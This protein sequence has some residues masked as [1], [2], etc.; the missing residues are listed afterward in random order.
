MILKITMP[1]NMTSP[2]Q[3]HSFKMKPWMKKK[4]EWWSYYC[5]GPH[6]HL[7]KEIR[8]YSWIWP[9]CSL[10]VREEFLYELI[11]NLPNVVC[12]FRWSRNWYKPNNFLNLFQ[13]HLWGGRGKGEGGG[14]IGNEKRQRAGKFLEDW[15]FLFHQNLLRAKRWSFCYIIIW[16]WNV[17]QCFSIWMNTVS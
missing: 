16:S 12:I 8:S 5:L 10:E 15:L 1:A 11:A 13:L 7:S 17:N 9:T 6:S 2:L 3:T 14:V 4:A